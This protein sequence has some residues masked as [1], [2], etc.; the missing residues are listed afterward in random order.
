MSAP[1]VVVVGLGPAGPELVTA[2]TT[3]AIAAV[4]PERRWL[5]T[6]RHPSASAAGAH[7]SFDAVYDAEPTFEAVYRRIADELLAAAATAPAS[8][9][10]TP[11]PARRGS[12]SG[13]STSLVR[14]R[15]RTAGV[16]VEV[17]PALSFLDLAWVRL[18]VD[19]LEEGSR[20]VDGHRFAEAAAGERGPLLVAHCHNRRVLS[21]I[22]LAFEDEAPA[23]GLRAA[24]PRAARRARSSRS[25]GP[26][27]TAPSSPTT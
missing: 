18:G 22:K 16:D 21:D 12:S 26:T 4:P 6:T 3:A 13:P 9:C 20:L 27:S 14:R 17:L 11:Y 23:V 8:R 10:S 7:H 19:P 5:R 1:R 15:R 25:R 24:A 2:A